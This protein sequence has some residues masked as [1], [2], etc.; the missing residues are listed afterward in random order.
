VPEI[1]LSGDHGRIARWRR[2]QAL[3]RTADR[4]PDLVARL[5]EVAVEPAEIEVLRALGWAPGDDGRFRRTDGA[6]SD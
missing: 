5:D 3:R 6:V 4:R 1:L 2:A